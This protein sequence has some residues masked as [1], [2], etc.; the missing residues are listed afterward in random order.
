V[1][2]PDCPAVYAP[3]LCENCNATEGWTTTVNGPGYRVIHERACPSDPE[4]C[5]ECGIDHEE[6]DGAVKLC[7]M[8]ECAASLDDEGPTS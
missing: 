8:C 4:V 6:P 5:V 2:G 7:F 3:P 1:H